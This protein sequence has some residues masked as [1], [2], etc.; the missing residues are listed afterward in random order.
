[1]KKFF[2]TILTAALTLSLTQSTSAQSTPAPQPIQVE[3][4]DA[5]YLFRFVG[6]N[7]KNLPEDLE[8]QILHSELMM[9]SLLFSRGHKKMARCI[10]PTEQVRFDKDNAVI[11]TDIM[12]KYAMPSNFKF[13]YETVEGGLDCTNALSGKEYPKCWLTP[14]TL[15]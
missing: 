15:E 9:C 11:V 2:I 12:K 13:G 10:L 3:E 14:K 4:T 5:I 1:M 8:N 7:F 6:G